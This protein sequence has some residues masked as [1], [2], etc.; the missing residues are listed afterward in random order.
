[1]PGTPNS[2]WIELKETF[3][4]GGSRLAALDPA[5]R[6]QKVILNLEPRKRTIVKLE[7]MVA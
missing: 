4:Y 7:A 1:M 5:S 3:V 2:S 6:L